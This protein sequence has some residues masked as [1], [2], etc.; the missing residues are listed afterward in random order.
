[1]TTRSNDGI[2]Q[3][4]QFFGFKIYSS[5]RHPLMALHSTTPQPLPSTPSEF[6]QAIKSPHWF[7]AMSEEFSALINNQTWE[8][9]PCPPH[10]NII[11]NKWVFRVKQKADGSFDRFKAQL[12]AKGFQQ[13]DGVDFTETFSPIVKSPTILGH[14]CHCYSL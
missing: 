5:T 9:C 4:K 11:S 12:V 6:S 7:Q 1:M 2:I 14:P 10:K 8:L 13:E 3:P